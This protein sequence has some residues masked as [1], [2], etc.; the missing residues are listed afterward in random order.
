MDVRLH[1]LR[2]SAEGRE[3]NSDSHA[4]L[5]ESGRCRDRRAQIVRRSNRVPAKVAEEARGCRVFAMPAL[6]NKG[7]RSD[8]ARTERAIIEA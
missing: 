7:H 6:A 3:A 2:R 1:V 8:S 4:K 5:P